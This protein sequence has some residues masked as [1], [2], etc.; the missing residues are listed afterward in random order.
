MIFL[1]ENGNQ[2][3]QS[4]DVYI[5]ASELYNNLYPPYRY[6]GVITIT[7]E[8]TFNQW[9]GQSSINSNMYALQGQVAEGDYRTW[10]LENGS[11]LMVDKRSGSYGTSL[12]APDGSTTGYTTGFGQTN[13]GWFFVPAGANCQYQGSVTVTYDDHG[14]FEKAVVDY[15]Y[16]NTHDDSVKKAVQDFFNGINVPAE[17]TTDG[18]GGDGD[19]ASL[20]DTTDIGFPSLT[21]M[22]SLYATHMIRSY[23]LTEAQCRALASWFWD[24]SMSTQFK[25]FFNDPLDGIL[26]LAI[27]PVEPST[28][29]NPNTPIQ[30][31]TAVSATATGDVVSS[32]WKVVNCGSI[33]IPEAWG[34]FIDYTNT[35]V[36]LYL[37]YIGERSLSTQEVMSSTL[38]LRYYIDVLTGDCTAML[39][40]T[41]NPK[42]KKIAKLNSV[43]YNFDGNVLTTCPA[44]GVDATKRLMAVITGAFTL[45]AAIPT[46][47]ASAVAGASIA[48][49][50]SIMS[51]YKPDIL[52]VG[53]ITTN[54]GVMSVRSPFLTISRPVQSLPNSYAH[55]VGYPSNMSL[56]LG[57]CFGYTKV[58]DVQL[59]GITATEEEKRIIENLLKSGVYF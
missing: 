34:S 18:A 58:K 52:R 28:T 42:N 7:D 10:T 8:N 26:S 1:D 50:S 53:S 31:G 39:K 14:D 6:N 2:L 57:N 45:A 43:M 46:G 51:N 48:A 15:M 5:P 54:K 47:G 32:Q 13:S 30:I 22:P 49:G 55:H 40:I 17:D 20:Y 33:T 23:A 3:F 12:H 36:T 24:D 35:R 37:P 21:N 25:K 9:I 29:G 41:K 4:F 38:N 59:D 27:I 11:Y 44:T 56:P 16:V 19:Y